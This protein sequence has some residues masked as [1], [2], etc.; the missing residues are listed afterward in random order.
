VLEGEGE[1]EGEGEKGVGGAEEDDEAWETP[2]G[3]RREA[4]ATPVVARIEPLSSTPDAED[5]PLEAPAKRGRLF[6]RRARS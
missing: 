5:E 6:K 4:R 2:S 1:G 3:G